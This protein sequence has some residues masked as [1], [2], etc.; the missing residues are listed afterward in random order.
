MNIAQLATLTNLKLDVIAIIP[1]R[2][3]WDN[4]LDW[5]IYKL[6]DAFKLIPYDFFLCLKLLRIVEILILA[7]AAFSKVNTTWGDTIR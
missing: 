6:A 1:W 5:R 7:A 4:G 2:R 3:G